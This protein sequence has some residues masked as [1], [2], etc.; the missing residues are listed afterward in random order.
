MK[1]YSA[2]VDIAGDRNHVVVKRNITPAE[3]LALQAIHG[4]SSVHTIAEEPNKGTDRTPHDV[5]R[6]RLDRTYGRTRVG[7]EG[8]RRPAL[9]AAM[10]DWPGG[11]LPADVKAAGIPAELLAEKPAAA[12]KSTKSTAKST[13]STAKS[14]DGKDE[15][16]KGEGE[17]EQFME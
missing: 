16:G 6:A 12:A 8:H 7:P 10:P 17:A 11:N 2:R 9:V 1:Y 3:I 15:E 14:D 5:I 13:K 4:G